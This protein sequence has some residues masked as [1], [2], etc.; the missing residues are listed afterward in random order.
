MSIDFVKRSSFEGRRSI[1]AS[2]FFF[3]S[4]LSSEFDKRR[5]RFGNASPG[6]VRSDYRGDVIAVGGACCAR[7]V[8]DAFQGS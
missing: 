5:V 8:E 3:F 2:G 1:P 6:V 4:P 7:R